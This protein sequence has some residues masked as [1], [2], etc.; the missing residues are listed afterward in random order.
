VRLAGALFGVVLGVS[1]AAAGLA[2]IP[3]VTGPVVDQA[4]VIDDA[5]ARAITNLAFEL[6]Q[7]TGAEIA[8][9]TVRTTAPED[10]FQYGMRVADAWKLGSAEKDDGLLLVVAVDDRKAHFFTGYGLEGMLPDGK[11]GGILD[12]YVVPAFR[13]GD[14]GGGS[15]AGLR[16]GAEVIAADAG[17]TLSG[18]PAQPVRRRVRRGPSPFAWIWIIIVLWVLFGR[19]GRRR[20]G[21]IP[22]FFGGGFGGHGGGG[23]GGTLGGG[24]GGGFGG[25]GGGFGGFGGGGGGFGGGG[26]GRG[27]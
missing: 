5:R 18:T 8:V 17:V 22:P 7:K 14:Y 21:F 1:L 12:E 15:Y 26:A 10:I 24:F 20:G 25:G 19:R 9:L 6:K 2:P 13:Q 11:L 16:T 27:W 23:Y 3:P 4:D